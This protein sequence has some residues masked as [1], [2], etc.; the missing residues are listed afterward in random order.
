M[1]L[2]ESPLDFIFVGA[3]KCGSTWFYKALDAHPNVHVPSAKD[4]YFFDQY[5]HKGIRW[6]HDIVMP[7][8]SFVGRKGELSHDYMFDIDAMER[9]VN[10]NKNIKII[11]C[12][13]NPIERCI[14]AFRFMKRNGTDSNTFRN[15]MID[16]PRLIDQSKYYKYV[17][18]CL[19]ILPAYNV[20]IFIF[21][22]LKDNSL[23]ILKELYSFIGVDENYFYEN[24]AKKE[25]PA[26][27]ARIQLLAN[28][29]KKIARLL[30]KF[31]QPNL[32]GV[33]KHSF[34]NK[35]LYKRDY[36]EFMI[37]PADKEW[38]L[39]E[40]ISDVCL[41]EQLIDRDLSTWKK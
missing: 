9:I 13:R 24:H 17:K 38:L 20:K 33:V 5:Y 1:S 32:I 40:F 22:D 25:L 23:L 11:M 39:D 37:Q 4:V 21:D 26:S 12:L 3:A 28:I 41:L 36:T 29:A 6:Y 7:S 31:G 35:L 15:T 8:N 27:K 19:D 2:S 10:Y 30:R 34:M 16:N 14:S 18:Y